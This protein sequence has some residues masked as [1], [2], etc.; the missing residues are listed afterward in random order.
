MVLP[1]QFS[2]IDIGA[3]SLSQPVDKNLLELQEMS[4][5]KKQFSE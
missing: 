4:R 3:P 1:F 5:D 2:E